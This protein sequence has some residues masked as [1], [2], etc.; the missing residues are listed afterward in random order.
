M[1]PA[2]FYHHLLEKRK[3]QGLYRSLASLEPQ[4][5]YVVRNGK[6]LLNLASNDYLSLANHPA[7]AE[8]GTK[9]QTQ[10]GSGSTGSRLLSGSLGIFAET[11]TKLAQW[12]NSEAALY[13][14]SGYT[15]NL[16]LVSALADKDCHLFFDR[17]NHA[18]LYDGAKFSDAHLHRFKH[19]DPEDLRRLLLAY[20]GRGWIFTESVFSMDGDLAPLADYVQLS[21]EFSV[22][23]VVDEAHADGVFGPG[24]RGLVHALGLENRV[25]VVM[26]TLG[27]ALGCAG[28]CVWA[29]PIVIEWLV[30]NARP[31]IYSTAQTPSVLGSVAR[32]INLLEE[33]SWRRTH[34][35]E[36][37][38]KLR[39]ALHTAGFDTLQ[40]ASQIIPIILGSNE[41]ALSAS[42][43]LAE[44]GYWSAPIRQPTVPQ[45]TARLRVNVN[46]GHSWEQLEGF[47]K[48]LENWTIDTSGEL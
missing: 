20:P 9:A 24:G 4:G 13:F 1:I 12:K 40:S 21:E 7:L 10:W 29:K 8:A 47:V 43:Y 23:I 5:M 31:F 19:N 33:E 3:T 18:S 36:L 34:V 2:E 45:G 42:A 41:R 27:K 15:A 30:N 16:S 26:G 28:A 37:A 17:L 44:H 38:S 39:S 6:K 32:A 11:E 25:D 48:V 46:A 35:L 14:N 22:G